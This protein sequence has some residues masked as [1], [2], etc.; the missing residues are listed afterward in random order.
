MNPPDSRR[1][2]T[3]NKEFVPNK[4]VLK[5]TEGKQRWKRLVQNRKNHSLEERFLP[6][7][8]ITKESF[9]LEK[10]KIVIILLFS[11]LK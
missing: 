7:W 4:G 9:S 11:I 1:R 5:T 2:I 6:F 3:G 10:K 8:K